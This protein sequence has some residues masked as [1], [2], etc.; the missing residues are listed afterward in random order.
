LNSSGP[1]VSNS[2]L[3]E[4]ADKPGP[5]DAHE[6]EA[7]RARHQPIG[8]RVSEARVSLPQHEGERDRDT[9]R[10]QHPVRPA[11]IGDGSEELLDVRRQRACPLE[12]EGIEQQEAEG[13]QRDGDHHLIEQAQIS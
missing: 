10:D 5:A 2:F 3:G 7:D 1:I 11:D 9:G 6:H 4:I 13:E 12:H 8:R